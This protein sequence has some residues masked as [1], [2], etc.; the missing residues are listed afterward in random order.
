MT[1]RFCCSYAAVGAT[2]RLQQLVEAG[3]VRKA[4]N[5]RGV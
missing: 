1:L 3:N 2:G 4:A 5:D